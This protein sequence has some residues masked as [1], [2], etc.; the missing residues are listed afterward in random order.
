MQAQR[1]AGSIILII[2][3]CGARMGWVVKA[4]PQLFYPQEKAPVPL[5]RTLCGPEGR[6]RRVWSRDNL[7]R[8]ATFKPLT[9][10]HV[11]SSNTVYAISAASIIMED[12]Y[13]H[14]PQAS[15]ILAVGSTWHLHYLGNFEIITDIRSDNKYV[16]AV[17][18]SISYIT[19][20]LYCI[21]VTNISLQVA[22][23]LCI[24]Q[25]SFSTLGIRI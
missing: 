25:V 10:K 6:C 17:Q 9:T 22:F 20:L 21:I 19:F 13:L 23:K 11:A 16:R 4:K 3:N 5:Y 8:P 15:V 7:S 24:Q 1:G 18:I 2:F 12:S 14:T